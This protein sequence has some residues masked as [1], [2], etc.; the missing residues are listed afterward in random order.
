MEY[1]INLKRYRELQSIQHNR[2]A[3]C[4]TPRGMQSSKGR[5]CVD[6]DKNTNK[7]RGLLCGSCNIALGGFQ[8]SV[9]VLY[10]AIKYL[11]LNGNT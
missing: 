2:C 9:D 1:N 7:V 5:L 4:N 6:H 10:S 8:H 11:K 3:I